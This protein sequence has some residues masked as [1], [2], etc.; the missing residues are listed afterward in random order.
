M[1]LTETLKHIDLDIDLPEPLPKAFISGL[2]THSSH[3]S[4]SPVRDLFQF[5]VDKITNWPKHRK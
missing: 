3:L 2:Q 1:L 5:L 4:C